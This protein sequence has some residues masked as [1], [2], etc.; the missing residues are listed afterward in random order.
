[1]MRKALSRKTLFPFIVQLNP[2][3]IAIEAYSRAH[4][5]AR[6]FKSI[7]NQVSITA[8]KFIEPFAL[9]VKGIITM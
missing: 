2:C 8:A 5:W 3:L 6:E 9:A 1:M 4:Y 7:A